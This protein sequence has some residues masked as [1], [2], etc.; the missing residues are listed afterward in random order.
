[1]LKT[2]YKF[3]I[4][5]E[6]LISSEQIAYLEQAPDN[7]T[8]ITWIYVD[9]DLFPDIWDTTVMYQCGSYIA[10]YIFPPWLSWDEYWDSLARKIDWFIVE[11]LFSPALEWQYYESFT[12]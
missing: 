6:S 8:R 9:V 1:M 7:C 12:L 2:Y 5:K 11:W 3:D 4:S 10:K